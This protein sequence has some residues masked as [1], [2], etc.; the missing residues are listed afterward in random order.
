MPNL[1][2]IW[3]TGISAWAVGDDGAIELYD[4]V[5]WSS[6]ESPVTST[7]FCVFG[8]AEN[9]LWAAGQNGQVLRSLDGVSWRDAGTLPQTVRGLWGVDSNHLWACGEFGLISYWNG[10]QWTTQSS[11]TSEHLS[12]ISGFN[13]SN[14][15]AVGAHGVVSYWNGAIWTASTVGLGQW[16][17]AFAV[18]AT[19]VWLAG[20]QRISFWDGAMWSDQFT[21]AND[22]AN[23]TG[24]HGSSTTLLNAVGWL[25]GD[26]LG[27]RSTD[28][29]NWLLR[30]DLPMV[31]YGC[32]AL[33][34]RLLVVGRD[35][36]KVGLE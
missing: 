31:A 32:R 19:H 4:G 29:L 35:E 30:G 18:D 25:D 28:G 36:K 22:T 14:V 6:L 24:L 13:G 23:F 33:S 8:F 11:G 3:G 2:G 16:N 1:Y 9:D 15:W 10:S 21:A 5:R 7:L 34:G 20:E 12:A 26:A 17:A 27:Y